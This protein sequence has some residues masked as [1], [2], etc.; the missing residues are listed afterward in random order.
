MNENMDEKQIPYIA[1]EIA[2][3]KFERT[4]KRLITALVLAIILIAVSNFLWLYA[5]MQYDYALEDFE[6]EYNVELDSGE[7]GIANYIGEKGRI[8][9]GKD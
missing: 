1:Y 8:Y 6:T 9:N 5:W 3:V 7:S 4:E 2:Q